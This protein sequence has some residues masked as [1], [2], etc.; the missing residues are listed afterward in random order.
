[1]LTAYHAQ[2]TVWGSVFGAVCDFFVCIWSISRITECICAKFTWKTFWSL[3][4]SSLNVK[5]KVTSDKRRHFWPF[6]R[7]AC[8]LCLVKHLQPLVFSVLWWQEDMERGCAKRLPARNLNKEDAM[9]RGRWKKLIKIGWWSVWWVG[10]CFFGWVFL[11]VPVHPGSPGQRAVKWSLL[12][13]CITIVSADCR[14][15]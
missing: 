4:R 2:W 7:P 10:E 5:V 9:D 3:T 15:L 12:C 8:V 11:L 1:M 6:R 13:Y 14:F